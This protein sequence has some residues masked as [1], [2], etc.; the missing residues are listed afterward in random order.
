MTGL[1]SG[2]CHCKQNVEGRRCDAC[3]AGFWDFREENPLGCIP[4]SCNQLGTVG[5]LG[6]D[7]LTGECVC[8]R[9]VVGRDCN[10]C[11]PEFYGLGAEEEG[12]KPC[13]CD[14]GGSY[15]NNCDIISGQCKC[16]PHVTG[17]KCDKPANG[18]FSPLIDYL[19]YE[20]EMGRGSADTQV[21]PREPYPNSERSWTGD[22]FIRTFDKSS[23][24]VDIR[25]VPA[26][27]EYDL[28]VRYEPTGRGGRPE[29]AKVILDRLTGPPEFSGLCGNT[30]DEEKRIIFLPNDRTAR[31]HPAPL[32]L[33]RGKPYRIK[34]E[35][36]PVLDAPRDQAPSM[37]I[38]SVSRS[39]SKPLQLET[40]PTSDSR[41]L[42][43]SLL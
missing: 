11:A 23:V 4:C 1:V 2:K 29:E 20:G 33:E 15:D 10:Q 13:D 31:M 21:V 18:Y 5:N 12:C 28:V 35:M 34:L 32:C 40:T 8:K 38:D 19:R 3:K 6:C 39:N 43:S 30:V 26:T 37:L 9:N 27:L 14:D 36:I 16:R 42:T 24:E 7:V 22:G 17:Q 25:N 41:L